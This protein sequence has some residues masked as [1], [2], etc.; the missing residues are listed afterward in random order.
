V[1]VVETYPREFYVPLGFP[2]RGWSKRRQSDRVA[3]GREL[4]RWARRNGIA[5][6]PH[7]RQQVSDGFGASKLGEDP[8]DALVGLLGM[9]GVV[10]GQL[11]GSDPPRG[12][13]PS[14][15]TVEGWILGRP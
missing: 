13:S 9:I 6:D 1:V 2:T 10:R 5:L 14:V 8:F 11:P 7:A 4:L 3:R 12:A 15:R